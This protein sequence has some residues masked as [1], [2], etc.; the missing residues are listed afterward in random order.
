MSSY[1][2]GVSR[3]GLC[4][5][6]KNVFCGIV[7]VMCVVYRVLW[8]VV[9]L[10]VKMFFVLLCS[11]MCALWCCCACSLLC[12]EGSVTCVV[13]GVVFESENDFCVC[14]VCDLCMICVWF[15]CENVFHVLLCC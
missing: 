3:V 1:M 11:C 9:C 13:C 10:K 14:C 5:K 7:C 8:C 12:V 6:V 2:C 15:E 4:L